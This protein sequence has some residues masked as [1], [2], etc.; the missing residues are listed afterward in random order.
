MQFTNFYSARL[1]R[2]LLVT[3][4]LTACGPE[5]QVTQ[6]GTTTATADVAAGAVIES[7]FAGSV[8]DGPIVNSTVTIISSSGESLV[9]TDVDAFANYRLTVKAGKKSYP[10]YVEVNGGTD[11]VTNARPSFTL[12]SVASD[13]SRKVVNINP[14]STL[15]VMTAKALGGLTADNVDKA[16]SLVLNVFNFGLDSALVADPVNDKI[17]ESNV[18]SMVKASEA[19]AEMIRRTASILAI[20]EDKVIAALAADIVDGVLDGKGAAG[21]DLRTALVAKLASGQVMLETISN[22][23]AV[24]SADATGAMDLAIMTVMPDLSSPVTTKT[25]PVTS[26][27]IEEVASSI[28]LAQSIAPSDYLTQMQGALNQVVSGSSAEDASLLLSS[29]DSAA[30]SDSLSLSVSLSDADVESL[31]QNGQIAQPTPTTQ[32]TSVNNSPVIGGAPITAVAEGGSYSFIPSASDADGDVLAFS[33]A[34]KPAWAIF[35]TTT[36]ELSGAPGYDD[37]GSYNNIVI[38]ASDGVDSVYLPAFTLDVTDTNRV[39][40]ISGS[41]TT[42]VAEGASYSFVP[43]ASDADGDALMFSIA[44]KPAWA[45]FDSTTG[46]LTGAPGF[47]ASGS[48]ADI[49]IGVSDGAASS[50]LPAFT[51]SVTNTNQVPVIS[52]SPATSVA[53]GNGYNFVPSAS[54]ADG[55]ALVFSISNKPAWAAFSSTTGALTGVPGYNESGNYSNI[56]IKVSDGNYAASLAP[57]SISVTNTNRVPSANPVSVSVL[58][59]GSVTGYMAGTDP[60]G[61]ALTYSITTAPLNGKASLLNV[62]TGQF[63]YTP[64]ANYNGADSITYKV[65]DGKGGFATS[66][67]SIAVQSVNDIPVANADSASVDSGSSVEIKVL[68]NDTG[69]G[70]GGLGLHISGAPSLGTATVAGGSIVYTPNATAFGNDGFTYKLVDS[71]GDVAYGSVSVQVTCASCMKTVTA[72]WNPNSESDLKGYYLYHGIESGNYA[73]RIWVGNVT[74]YQYA[75]NTSGTHYFAV[76]AVNQD[77]LE[78][79][80]S[81]EISITQ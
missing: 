25:V 18:A 35:D 77:G 11:L 80:Y 69:L 47:G 15:I 21:T 70:D 66:V 10:L 14:H 62:A 32:D 53:E 79:G 4:L 50:Y 74:Q 38:G 78:S 31:L 56:T 64:D 19:L 6:T 52:G 20:N 30:F 23:L 43:V 28:D 1:L 12:M 46:A 48:Y 81:S 51:L 29:T 40:V 17:T 45:S 60:D 5:E 71:N 72:S 36:G 27:A 42:T 61:D 55:D 54:D 33:I 22:R 57:F 68:A 39:P 44:N 49:V 2:L 75:L 13:P 26:A 59:D 9:Q 63:S 65:N 16:T 34:N 24:N 67:V 76:T 73:D 58:E 3:F 8:G 41:P 7:T 37:A